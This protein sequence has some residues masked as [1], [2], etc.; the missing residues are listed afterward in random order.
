M[1]LKNFMEKTVRSL[2]FTGYDS[3]LYKAVIGWLAGEGYLA[4]EKEPEP[5]S[6]QRFVTPKGEAAGLREIRLQEAAPQSFIIRYLDNRF[7]LRQAVREWKS[8]FRYIMRQCPISDSWTERFR[9][10]PLFTGNEAYAFLG[11]CFGA[12]IQKQQSGR[13]PVSGKTPAC[14]TKRW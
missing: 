1:T 6:D 12:A 7:T 11:F 13:S 8:F 5:D 3:F 9:T 10:E 4:S 2:G 14:S